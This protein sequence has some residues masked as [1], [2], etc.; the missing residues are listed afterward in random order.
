[1][2]KVFTITKGLEN[3]G[4]LH[5]G[6]QGSVY[7]GKRIGE[8]YVAV[9]L[10]PTPI[11]AESDDD[12][13]YHDFMN[14]V[15]KLKKVNQVSNPNVVKILSS[16]ITESGSLPYIEME[17]IE[18]PD[19][20]ELLTEKDTPVFTVPEAIKVAYQLANALSHCH[21]VGVK[22][23][24][25]K[26]NNVKFN[27]NTGNYVLLD[28]GL[29][30]M[31]D[32]QRRSS[33]RQAGAVEFMAPEQSEGNLLPQSDVY[34]YGIILY[35]LLAG[36]VPFK[37][38]SDSQTARNTVMI[39]HLEQEPPNLLALREKNMPLN[40]PDEQRQREMQ[41]PEWLLTIIYKCLQKNPAERFTDGTELRQAIQN[42]VLT[43]KTNT[44]GTLILENENANLKGLL[45]AEQEKN[46]SLS[47]QVEE[48]KRTAAAQAKPATPA[49]VPPSATDRKTSK[50]PILVIALLML[51]VG[52]LAGRYLFKPKVA[53][54]SQ[55][56]TDTTSG[57]KTKPDKQ[58]EIKPDR[59]TEV[60][61][62]PVVEPKKDSEAVV[63]KPE[64]KP[65][66]LAVHKKPKK[67]TAKKVAVK[68]PAKP[69]PTPPATPSEPAKSS[70][71]GKVYSL[72][73]TYA[74]FYNKPDAGTKRNAYITQWDNAR[75][76]ALEERD[77]FIYVVFT[78]KNGETSRG[79][80]SKKDLIVI[81][82]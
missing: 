17:F 5:T 81:G 21:K 64:T 78:N 10:L 4:A 29:A 75:L 18:G 19:L 15:E 53:G 44:E 35:E 70:G 23:G 7:K 77:G 54:V 22:H 51:I 2:G 69:K 37:L 25:I 9:K 24:D 31:T 43:V 34:S 80:L 16:G 41:V 55:P 57:Y 27:T 73:T 6:G 39:E 59:D 12:K 11:A 20:A 28:F 56:A 8:I 33:L 45:K 50:A 49:F 38:N 79:W 3:M 65:E 26:S 1:M 76:R 61:D 46:S 66:T 52:G 13:H 32:E 60:E 71:T 30:I 14:E 40:W 58:A 67:D 48:L 68:T 82:Q 36:T 74:Y 42:S 47:S 63:K 62:K 72:F